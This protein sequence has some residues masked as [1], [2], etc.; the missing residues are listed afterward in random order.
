VTERVPDDVAELGRDLAEEAAAAGLALRLIGGV[1]VW[2]RCPSARTAP[3]ARTYGDIDFVGRA[4]DRKAIVAF[5]ADS[6][7]TGCS[8]RCMARR[9]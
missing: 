1:A 7:R 6:S 2:V 8:T 3:L 5:L 9:G 4:R